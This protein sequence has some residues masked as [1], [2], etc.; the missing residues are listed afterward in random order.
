[1]QLISYFKDFQSQSLQVH[2][3]GLQKYS[4]RAL[5]QDLVTILP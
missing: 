4:R 3:V 1:M 2:A 5:T